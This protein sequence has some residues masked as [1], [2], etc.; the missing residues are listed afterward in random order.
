MGG[1]DLGG[2]GGLW[3]GVLISFQKAVSQICFEVVAGVFC[4][5][6]CCCL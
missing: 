6:V 3:G 5:F 2:E 4:L 1:A